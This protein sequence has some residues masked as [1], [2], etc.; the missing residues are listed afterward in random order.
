MNVTDMLKFDALCST[1]L[2][3]RQRLL[4]PP[5][6]RLLRHASVQRPCIVKLYHDEV[7]S[8]FL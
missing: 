8:Y 4:L 5:I 6:E 1:D 2:E 3:A 7:P